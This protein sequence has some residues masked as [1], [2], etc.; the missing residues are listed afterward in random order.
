MQRGKEVTWIAN[1]SKNIL[2]DKRSRPLLSCIFGLFKQT[3][4]FL[5]QYVKNVYP[6]F[7]AEIWTQNLYNVNLLL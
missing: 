4:Q 7:G 3:S 5:Q 2:K 1:I 6:V